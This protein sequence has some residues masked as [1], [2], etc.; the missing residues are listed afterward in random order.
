MTDAQDLRTAAELFVLLD[1]EFRRSVVK[2]ALDHHA[3]PGALRQQR[4]SALRN[5]RVDGYRDASRAPGPILLQPVL[6]AIN[7]GDSN[8]ARVAL[9][10]WAASHP[11]LADK[12]AAFLESRGV[13]FSAPADGTFEDYWTD[14]DWQR[15][16]RA[17]EEF[18]G[19]IDSESGGLMLCLLARRFPTPPLPRSEL[20]VRFLTDLQ[21]LPPIAPEWE[22]ATPLIE[23]VLD[24][25][26]AKFR[27]LFDYCNQ[28]VVEDSASLCEQFAD[29]LGYLGIDPAP[30]PGLV[31]ERPAL[32]ESALE[33][34]AELREGLEDY[35][36]LRPQASTRAEEKER[37]VERGECEETLLSAFAG[38]QDRV[39]RPDPSPASVS[40]ADAGEP[41]PP[42][43]AA[44][45][46]NGQPAPDPAAPGDQD[47]ARLEIEA[48]RQERERLAAD[49]R[50]LRSER[51]S[52]AEEARRLRAEIDQS[53]RMEEH[54]RRAYVA[55]RRQARV[56]DGDPE[57][58]EPVGSVR[59]A[60]AQA[61]AMFP[62]R[63][64][65]KLNSRSNQDTP[66][67]NPPEVLD[68]LAWLA[69][70]YR[71]GPDERIGETCPGWFYKSHQSVTTMGQF[72]EWYRV[73]VNGTTWELS[74]HLGKGTSHDPHH[75]I[76]IGFAWEEQQER[77]IVGYIGVHQRNRAT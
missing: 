51:S 52:V 31:E 61:Q 27:E 67:V 49:C 2:R 13:P 7:S 43:E 44:Q 15:R 1:E 35:R 5:L 65:I 22:E 50:T 74:A 28:R 9:N 30:C 17:L 10:L 71:N 58:P 4:E 16:R 24:L 57:A 38:W 72:P 66:F 73:Q 48:L 64:L 33:L 70:G 11:D 69:T 8:L 40:E 36:P 18:C 21:E 56:Q 23:W 53:R 45:R 6:E 77:V 19:D 37:A 60:L 20:F 26:E 75:T 59:E 63:L 39:D 54:W 68:A 46:P 3:E 62:D 29:E 14:E 47:S 55:E 42:S 34:L 12:A 32:L 41:Y 76:R 25:R